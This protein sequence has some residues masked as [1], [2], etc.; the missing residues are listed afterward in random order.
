[1]NKY[2]ATE[3]M[4][5]AVR[6]MLTFNGIDIKDVISIEHNCG[7]TAIRTE[8]KTYVLTLMETEE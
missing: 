4:I 3:K 5:L 8:N 7:S 2:E 1:M 6:Q